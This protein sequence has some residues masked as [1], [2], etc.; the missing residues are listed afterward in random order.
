MLDEDDNVDD[1]DDKLKVR[2]RE[3]MVK[4]AKMIFTQNVHGHQY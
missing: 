2:E 4:Y 1:E 3:A